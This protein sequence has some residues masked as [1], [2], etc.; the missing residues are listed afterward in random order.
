MML[1]PSPP[2]M[3][4]FFGIHRRRERLGFFLSSFLYLKP[5]SYLMNRLSSLVKCK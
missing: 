2:S 5:F 3:E 1:L 4:F